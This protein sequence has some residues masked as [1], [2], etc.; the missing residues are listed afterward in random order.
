MN[1][2][3]E[4][5]ERKR[6]SVKE[7]RERYDKPFETDAEFEAFVDRVLAKPNNF[8]NQQQNG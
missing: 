6:M 4:P 7:N 5:R 1:T 2:V 8:L 3:T